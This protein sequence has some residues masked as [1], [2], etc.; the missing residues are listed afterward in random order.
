[1]T[2]RLTAGP[3]SLVPPAG[4]KIARPGGGADAVLFAPKPPGGSFQPNLVVN[5]EVFNGSQ[6]KLSTVTLAGHQVMLTEYHLIDVDV[7]SAPISD[8]RRFEYMHRMGGGLL[9]CVQYSTVVNGCSVHMTFSAAEGQ[10]A[11]LDAT[12]LDCADSV[13]VVA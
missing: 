12:F 3:L 4:W 9:H 6:A 8:G 7:W 11:G 1:M 2:D 5:S 13:E 10:L